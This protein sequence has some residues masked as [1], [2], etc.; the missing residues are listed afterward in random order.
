MASRKT[1]AFRDPGRFDLGLFRR[2]VPYRTASVRSHRVSAERTSRDYSH[3]VRQRTPLHRHDH[4]S[5]LPGEPSPTVRCTACQA[6]HSFRPCRSTR[7]RRFAPPVASQVCCTLQPIMGFAVFRCPRARHECRARRSRTS[8]LRRYAL[9]SLSLAS[10]QHA[11]PRLLPSRRCSPWTDRAPLARVRAITSI[12]RPQG[13]APLA[14]PLQD[15]P[16]LPV[17]CCT[18]LPWASRSVV[19]LV[20]PV[21]HRSYGLTAIGQAEGGGTSRSP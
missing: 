16:P 19:C 7:L 11:S 21:A 15:A 20:R 6:V 14:K 10:S 12:T 2:H 3:G 4:W 13:L 1:R 9:R 18:L 5:P 17:E 8:P